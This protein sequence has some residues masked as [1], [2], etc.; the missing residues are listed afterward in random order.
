MSDWIDRH[1]V[2]CYFCNELV[3]ERLCMPADAFNGHDGGD[4]CPDCLALRLQEQLP[5]DESRPQDH[6]TVGEYVQKD[7]PVSTILGLS[8]GKDY[9]YMDS[10]WVRTAAEYGI[11]E[12]RVDLF[13]RHSDFEPGDNAE[14]MSTNMVADKNG[15]WGQGRPVAVF[16]FVI[17]SEVRRFEQ[18]CRGYAVMMPGGDI[19]LPHIVSI[20]ELARN[21]KPEET[22]RKKL[23]D[24]LLAHGEDRFRFICAHVI[25]RD[26]PAWVKYTTDNAKAFDRRGQV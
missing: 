13:Q 14:W 24:D 1:S 2:N 23:C 15:Y 21:T 22:H 25:K 8:D 4:I 17:P 18:F 19:L 26:T 12:M 6:V 5:V 10:A 11:D 3:D 16:Y 9:I 7:N 20:E